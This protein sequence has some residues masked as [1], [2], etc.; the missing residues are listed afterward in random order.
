VPVHLTEI[1]H[2]VRQTRNGLQR[3]RRRTTT[4]SPPRPTP[5]RASVI[6]SGATTVDATK[7]I[8][9][10]CTKEPPASCPPK[11][12]VSLPVPTVEVVLNIAAG[13]IVG[14]VNERYTIPLSKIAVVA[15]ARVALP[16][17][18]QGIT[19]PG[20]GGYRL[21]YDII[22]AKKRAKLR[23]PDAGIAVPANRQG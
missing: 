7:E 6:G 19:R 3:R 16:I 14:H 13:E 11:V 22:R 5:S 20:S 9:S 18:P 15:R 17:E 2:T 8:S 21:R 1:E 4:P 12:S 10:S 23:R